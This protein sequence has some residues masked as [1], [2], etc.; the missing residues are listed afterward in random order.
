LIAALQ[1]PAPA[2]AAPRP[3]IVIDPGHGGIDGGTQSEGGNL[4]EKDL[5]LQIAKR[6]ADKLRKAGY[7]VEMTRD[8]DQDVT[9]FAPP[10]IGGRHKRDLIGRV[11]AAKQKN[12]YVFISIHGNHGTSRNR[13]ALVF[14]KGNSLPSYHLAKHIQ[15]ELNGITGFTQTPLKGKYYVLNRSEIPGVLIEYGYLSNPSEVTSL[16][17]PAYQNRLA[18]LISRG[19]WSYLALDHSS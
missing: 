12:A 2:A 5:N 1:V 8:N 7:K 14:F 9:G 15:T 17:D 6:L 13:G 10:G 3:A 4:L 11:A 19:L 18:E 16:T